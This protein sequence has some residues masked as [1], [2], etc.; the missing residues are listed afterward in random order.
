MFNEDDK[1]LLRKIFN[2]NLSDR[3]EDGECFVPPDTSFAYVQRLRA[4]VKEEEAVLQL[5]KDHFF[6][7]AFS[8]QSPGPVFPASWKPVVEISRQESQLH[9]RPQ[10][11]AQAHILDGALRSAVPT[12]DQSTEEGTRFRVYQLGS[13]EVRTTQE[14]NSP[15]VVGAVFSTRSA[16]DQCVKDTE[17][18]VKSTEYVEGSSKAPRCFVVLE[19]AEKN[20][21]VAEEFADGQAKLEKNASFLEGRISLAKVIR[22]SDCK[23][24]QRS[25]SDIMN[26]QKSIYSYVTGDL[27]ES[28][29]REA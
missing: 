18:I 26:C 10:Y 9:P 20:M 7:S 16:V 28:G 17:R 5:R 3:R 24:T 21:I 22:S 27:A 8:Q 1:N 23:A 29:F 4:L 15:E 2:P 14:H 13:L 11:L 25:V 12:F 19:T 6:S